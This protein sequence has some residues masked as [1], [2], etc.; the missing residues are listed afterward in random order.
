MSTVLN[1]A[2][3]STAVWMIVKVS[4]L[5]A[6]AG[7][8]QG[9]IGT[10]ASAAAR[11]LTW[12]LA[13]AGV[14]LLPVL[15]MLIPGWAVV[16]WPAAASRTVVS[17]AAWIERPDVTG[18]VSDR[19][20]GTFTDEKAARDASTA[21]RP[22]AAPI[23]WT[24]VLLSL[25]AIGALAVGV[26]F[27]AGAWTIRRCARTA[28][29]V[30]DPEWLS[31]V[32]EC[33]RRS[34]VRGPVRFLRSRERTMPM[35]FGI[36]RPAILIPA[37]GDTWTEDRRRAVLL[38]ELAH[39]ARRDCLTQLLAAV[40]CA[41]YWFHPGVWWSARRL[42]VERELACD[43]R[44]L[45][46][47]ACAP[48]YAGHLLELAYA[49]GDRQTPALAVGMARPRQLE[50]RLLAV[51][52]AARERGM[53]GLRAR[54]AGLA[55][56]AAVLLAL[57]GARA[58][59]GTVGAG[60]E[61]DARTVAPARRAASQASSAVDVP[62]QG[63]PPGTWEIRPSRTP[64]AVQVRLTEGRSSSGYTIPLARLE[65]LVPAS[66][67]DAGG[68]VHFTVRR[69]A[70]TFTFE[71][72]VR[73][74]V[75][76]GFFT[77]APSAA[78]PDELAKRG[79]AR[80]SPA[81]Q[82]A[83]ARQDIGFAFLDELT[84]QRYARPD[85]SQ[86]LRA[87]ANGIGLDFL[88]EMGRLGYRLGLVDALI[89]QRQSGVSTEFIREL[90]A[91]GLTGLSADDLV[92]ARNNGVDPEYVKE[93][94]ALGYR[95][96]SLDELIRLRNNGVDPEYVKQ[97]GALGYP[98]L[99][100]DELVRLRNHGVDPE[101]VRGLKQVGYDHLNLDELVSL[102]GSGITPDRVRAANVRAGTRLPLDRLKT[103]A[104]NGWK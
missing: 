47:G 79:L 104:A 82:Y 77:F 65:G 83:L 92:R 96:L 30:D 6:A 72:L 57:A 56:A 71:G 95:N 100:L 22:A 75:G 51:L 99:R 13:L 20:L 19:L 88:R 17:A 67:L 39:V 55:I 32:R 76:A 40:A 27:A 33:V 25:Y 15:S 1:D 44:V 41:V 23:P 59:T 80:P 14:L 91:Q 53:P 58:T 87:A 78:F 54:V 12:T 4:L 18:P 43:D 70:G 36:R 69:D 35:A 50:G 64:G 10:R 42:R 2:A 85:L 3:I 52:D 86:L 103:L 89:K 31:L 46:A 34:G 45:A 8:A 38:H 90:A 24:T 102:R 68:P 7:A 26:R 74:G 60:I 73:S 98:N 48:D 94:G 16:R 62:G 11:H 21:S 5:V 97:F 84:A 29:D 49:L 37:V 101:Y 28:I 61:G 93:L 66:L 63:G 81:E 9:L